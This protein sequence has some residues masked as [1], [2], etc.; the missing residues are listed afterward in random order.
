MSPALVEQM[1]DGDV[2][3]DAEHPT[4]P[5]AFLSQRQVQQF[6][7]TGVLVVPDVLSTAEVAEARAGLHGELAKYDVVRLSYL[8]IML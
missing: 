3:G 8:S 6:L 7:E 5:A 1:M 2:L 4:V